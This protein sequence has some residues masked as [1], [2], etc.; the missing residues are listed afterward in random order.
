MNTYVTPDMS[1]GIIIN[2][3]QAGTKPTYH[4][5]LDTRPAIDDVIC[6]YVD[7]KAL[8]DALFIVDNIREHKMKIRWTAV[9]VWTVQY[10]RKH[11][12]DLRIENGTLRIGQVSGILATRVTNMSKNT[13]NM[14]WLIDAL[15]NPVAGTQEAS[16]A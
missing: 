4:E 16:Y 10:K 1:T 8:K 5:Q 6:H 13:E 9:N 7:G 2:G 11:V 12:C 14:E 3:E 15:R